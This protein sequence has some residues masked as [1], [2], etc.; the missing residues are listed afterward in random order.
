YNLSDDESYVSLKVNS[1]EEALKNSLILAKSMIAYGYNTNKTHLVIDQ[2]YTNIYNLAIKLSRGITL[3]QIKAIYGYKQEENIGLHFYPTIQSAH[4][5]LPQLFGIPNVLVPIGPDEDAHLRSCRDVA[6]K[7][8]YVK[9]AVL[10]GI[11][12][13]GVDGEKMSKSRNNAIFLLDDEKSIK[14]KVFSAF[15]GGQ[16]SIEEHRKLGGN[17]DVDVAYLYL[18]SYFMTK[19]ESKSVYDDYKKGRLLSGELKAMLFEKLMSRINQFK[20]RYEKV[21]FKD[22]EKAVMT[23]ESVDLKKLV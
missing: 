20:E 6:D 8:G 2:L 12:L 4:V 15:S 3:S 13:P 10:H 23:N 11:F 22:I 16:T 18:K 9:P 14:K 5:I 17:P 21:S 1:Q 19:D 7:F